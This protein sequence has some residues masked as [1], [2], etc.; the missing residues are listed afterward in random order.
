MKINMT[1]FHNLVVLKERKLI[2]D[3]NLKIDQNRTKLF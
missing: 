3:N 2:E 1:L